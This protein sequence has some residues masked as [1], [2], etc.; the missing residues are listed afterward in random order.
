MQYEEFLEKW[1]E[2]ALN[3]IEFYKNELHNALC[4]LEHQHSVTDVQIKQYEDKIA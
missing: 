2:L 3:K 4:E 1:K